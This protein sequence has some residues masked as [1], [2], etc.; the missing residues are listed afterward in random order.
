MKIFNFIR[1][2]IYL[3]ISLNKHDF[4]ICQ[5][6]IHLSHYSLLRE[7]QHMFTVIDVEIN[8]SKITIKWSV[9]ADLHYTDPLK[10]NV[11]ILVTFIHIYKQFFLIWKIVL[12]STGWLFMHKIYAEF[13]CILRE[14]KDNKSRR[15]ISLIKKASIL[16]E[17][18]EILVFEKPRHYIISEHYFLRYSCIKRYVKNL[19]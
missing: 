1:W 2:F 19:R 15:N 8:N 12:W 11:D 13:A 14:Q 9:A 16:S 3:T 5:I 10:L 17:N 18:C 6:K 4:I 7:F